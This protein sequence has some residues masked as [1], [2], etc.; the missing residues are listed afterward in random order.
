MNCFDI[1]S[2]EGELKY[3]LT[4]DMLFHIVMME[5]NKCLVS[6][7]SSLLS[8]S[9]EEI[10]DVTIL[11]PIDYYT[12]VDAKNIILDIKLEMNHTSITDIEMQVSKEN[13]W[14][15]R[16]LF[17]SGRLIADQNPGKNY[18]ALK[19]VHHIGILDFIQK[20]N[21]AF[22]RSFRLMREDGTVYSDKFQI[23]TLN[24]RNINNALPAD[25]RAG[26]VKWGRLF[27]ARSWEEIRALADE[28]AVFREVGENMRKAAVTQDDLLRRRED[29][30][31][32]YEF[33]LSRARSMGRAEGIV[34]GRTEGLAENVKAL[35]DN[36]GLPFEKAAAALNISAEDIEKIKKML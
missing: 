18:E 1:S 32:D 16:T 5:S 22:Y 35:M 17:Y 9:V 34:E 15:N 10:T 4:N 30:I 33:G 11:N 27:R 26:L 25:D 23:H 20:D 28:D 19:D 36:L 3:R 7:L 24:L 14:A 31:R 2:L 21:D 6:L 12:C 29:A 13:Y 8:V